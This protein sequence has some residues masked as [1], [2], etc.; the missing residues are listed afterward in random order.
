VSKVQVVSPESDSEIVGYTPL[1]EAMRRVRI[2]AAEWVG[3]R[4]RAIRMKRLMD[5]PLHPCRTF[6]SR[7]GVLASAGRS[8]VY[9]LADSRGRVTGFKYIDPADRH[10]FQAAALGIDV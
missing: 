7:G 6:T 2:G 10:V 4:Q 5:T 3:R 9:T 1:A 8:Q